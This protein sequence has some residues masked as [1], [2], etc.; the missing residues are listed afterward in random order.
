M[1]NKV[2]SKCKIKKP[3]NEFPINRSKK[4][5]HGYYCRICQRQVIR[6][7]YQKN[8]KYYQK[9]AKR[10]RNRN[11]K[12][13]KDYKKEKGCKHCDE[14]EVCCFAFHHRKGTKKRFELADAANDCYSIKA[15]LE[16]IEKCDVV[17]GNCHSKIHAGI[18]NE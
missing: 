9:K 12:F 18:L 3:L 16:E 10:A 1:K 4:D 15:L 2:C 7:H 8:K 5:G 13:L 11:A 14:K 6:N 17:C